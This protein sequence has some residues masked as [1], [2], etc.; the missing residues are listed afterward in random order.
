MK[1]WSVSDAAEEEAA[2][3]PLVLGILG[4]PR[5]R[6]N[7]E[8][9]LDRVL[10]GA[11]AAGARIEVIALRELTF[12]SCRHCGGCDRTGSCVVRDDMQRVYPKLREARH[13]VLASP[14]QFAAVSA[15]T[16]MMVDRGQ[17]LWVL[18]Y[19]LKRPVSETDGERRGLFVATCGGPDHRVFEWAK[20][21]VKAFFNSAGFRYWEELFETQTD[22][23]P[24]MSERED[25]LARAE[26]L[27]RRLVEEAA[28]AGAGTQYVRPAYSPDEEAAR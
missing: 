14:I 25:L 18:K 1:H 24:P 15:N 9:V 22:T 17:A 26:D 27:G 21:T 28:T 16:K 10:A 2:V 7:T 19:R 12:A 3:R 20:P 13:L 23:P 4:S 6:S 5:A 8:V 11:R